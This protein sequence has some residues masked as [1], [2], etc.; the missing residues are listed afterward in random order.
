VKEKKNFESIEIRK[1]DI[2]EM[3]KYKKFKVSIMNEKVK[4]KKKNEYRCGK[5]IDMCR[6]KKVRKKGKVK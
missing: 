2:M 5:I 3:L 6:G 1:E 4:N